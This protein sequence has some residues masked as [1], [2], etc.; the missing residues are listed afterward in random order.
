LIL[1]VA[2]IT[3]V[4]F[5]VSSGVGNLDSSTNYANSSQAQLTAQSG[6]SQATS[7]MAASTT[8]GGLPCV[9]GPSSLPLPLTAGG[10]ATY[11]VTITY[12]ASTGTVIPCTGTGNT[13]SNTPFPATSPA[14]ATLSST[15]NLPRTTPVTMQEKVSVKNQN[16]LLPA[17]NFAMFSPGSV[18]L[19]SNVQVDQ[20]QGPPLG[21]PPT[22]YGGSISQCTDGTV[23]QGDVLSYAPINVNSNCTIDGNLYVAGNVSISNNVHVVGNVYAY[24]GSV[25]LTS[26]PTIG[27]NI[28]AIKING[29]G[30]TINAN[31]NAVTVNGS[32]FATGAISNTSKATIGGSIVPNDAAIASWVMPAQVAFPQLMSLPAAQEIAALTAAGYNVISVGNTGIDNLICSVFFL[33]ATLVSLI[34]SLVSTNTA[35]YA[36][37]C[38]PKMTGLG[39][40]TPYLFSTNMIWIL[41]GFQANGTTDF[42]PNPLQELLGT[43]TFNLSIIVPYG[44]ACKKGGDITFTNTT[45][46]D[47]RLNVLLY[48]PC[49]A[50]FTVSPSMNG[51][52]LAQQSIVATNQFQLNFDDLA[53]FDLPGASFPSAPV[54]TVQSK[55]VSNG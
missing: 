2:L 23:L 3:S 42:A 27:G 26:T 7:A 31:T 15:G 10:H 30:G 18:A 37:T 46:F 54:V 14:S 43:K 25:D 21:P 53:G 13:L 1:A 19:T 17:F 8:I 51:Q 11:S 35:I 38:T 34:D 4:T 40:L 41:G 22:V 45:T 20:V 16:Q 50:N 32:L 49:T 12:L 28:Y 55:T 36:P 47:P 39:I 9:I 5:A 24:G 29:S 48:T 44:T 6:L 52:I 33:P